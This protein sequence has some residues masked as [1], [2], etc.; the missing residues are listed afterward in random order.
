MSEAAIDFRLEELNKEGLIKNG[1]LRNP[2]DGTLTIN[3]GDILRNVQVANVYAHLKGNYAWMFTTQHLSAQIT[4]ARYGNMQALKQLGFGSVHKFFFDKEGLDM[5]VNNPVFKMKRGEKGK[6][7][8]LEGSVD[9]TPEIKE[10]NKRL[11]TSLEEALDTPQALMESYLDLHA[12]LTA[13]PEAKRLG[14]EGK[15]LEMWL[16]DSIQRTQSAYYPLGREPM[17]NTIYIVVYS[18]IKH[19]HLLCLII[20]LSILVI[21]R[22]NTKTK[23]YSL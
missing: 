5:L 13:L 10:F 11:T 14:F 19:S 4:G 18:Y 22:E 3:A 7:I 9:L 1:K 23:H 2:D 20:S 17:L 16:S 21:R 12:M 6:A 8:P 15:D